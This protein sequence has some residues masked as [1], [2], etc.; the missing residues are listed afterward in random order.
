MVDGVSSVFCHEVIDVGA[1]A[2]ACAGAGV[3]SGRCSVGCVV[4]VVVVVLCDSVVLVTFVGC[5]CSS[6]FWAALVALVVVCRARLA[7][8]ALFCRLPGD[9]K[10]GGWLALS[11]EFCGRR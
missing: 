11:S 8:K 10:S 4:L 2:S 6:G 3:A 1:S 5:H 9:D 7:L